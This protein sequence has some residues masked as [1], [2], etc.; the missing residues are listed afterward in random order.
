[1]P[2]APE[3]RYASLARAAQY[4]DCH[5][6]TLRRHIA[7]GD[8]SETGSAASFALTSTKSTHGLPVSTSR[9]SLPMRRN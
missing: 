2:P 8:L 4:A 5:E 9:N 6:R 3:R 1:M 7:A